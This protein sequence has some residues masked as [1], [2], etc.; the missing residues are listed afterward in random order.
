MAACFI[1]TTLEGSSVKS[2]VARFK[3]W[4]MAATDS[5]SITASTVISFSVH[6]PFTPS[7]TVSFK[8]PVG[9]TMGSVPRRMASIC[10]KPQGSHLEGNRV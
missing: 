6:R 8:P 10:T 4:L 5:S 1:F 2:F 7:S 9:A 3:A